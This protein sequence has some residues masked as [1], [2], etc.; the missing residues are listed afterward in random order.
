M[1]WCETE[2]Q[3]SIHQYLKNS[4]QK[5]LIFLI[6][7]EGDFTENEVHLAQQNGFIPVSLGTSI[8]RTETAA[9]YLCA[10]AKN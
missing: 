7:P 3:E 6:G 4:A 8:L 1:A 9:L 5:N 10:L 2:K